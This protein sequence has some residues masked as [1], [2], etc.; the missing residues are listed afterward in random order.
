MSLI[1]T[2]YFG[3]TSFVSPTC[4]HVADDAGEYDD[5]DEEDEEAA[6]DDTAI[7]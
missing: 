1:V 2:V 5:D 4:E 3:G 7:E 6:D